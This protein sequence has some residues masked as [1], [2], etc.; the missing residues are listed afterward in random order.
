MLGVMVKVCA[1][2]HNI[3]LPAARRAM[4]EAMRR[5]AAVVGLPL[6]LLPKPPNKVGVENKGKTLWG[7]EPHQPFPGTP[8]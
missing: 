4:A 8:K 2:S 6:L 3:L 7:G 5:P 1:V